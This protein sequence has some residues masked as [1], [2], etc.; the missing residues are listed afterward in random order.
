[1]VEQVDVVVIG[2]GLSGISAA[3]LLGREL[4]DQ[5]YLVL[6][7]RDDV[8][9]TWDLFRYPGVRS[10][11]D[12]HTLGFSFHPWTD[13]KAIA[14]G[15]QIK[16]YIAETIDRFGVRPNLRLGHRMVSADWST[17]RARWR[18]VAERGAGNA[19]VIECRFL[20]M[21]SGYYNYR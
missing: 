9:G 1:M 12:M 14:G 10:D 3:A 13:R 19:V 21:G 11:S 6:E 20:Y 17:E 2:A 15:D 5:R 16:R 8:G 18:I 7:A 4:S